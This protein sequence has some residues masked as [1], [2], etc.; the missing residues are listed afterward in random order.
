MPEPKFKLPRA[1]YSELVK[2]LRAYH[3]FTTPVALADVS[4]SA[5]IHPTA[6]SRNHG[7]LRSVGILEGG[8][9]KMLTPRGHQL[10]Q[11]LETQTR[12]DA[13]RLWREFVAASALVQEVLTAVRRRGSL[14]FRPLQSVIAE[15]SGERIDAHLLTGAGALIEI[16]KLAGLLRKEAG[17]ELAVVPPGSL[18]DSQGS[19]LAPRSPDFSQVIDL[20][21]VHLQRDGADVSVAFQVQVQCTPD[22]LDTLG[23]RLVRVIED[24]KSGSEKE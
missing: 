19:E 18:A 2:V 23:E 14:G 1:S 12:S 13:Q 3:R 21:T 5:G 11:A 20:P 22:E 9:R 7:F 24:L 8:L 15:Y 17:G 16:L 6:V 10:V 4:T